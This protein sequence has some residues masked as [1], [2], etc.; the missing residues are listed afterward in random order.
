MRTFTTTCPRCG[1]VSLAPEQIELWVFPD[2]F[3]EDGYAFTCPSCHERIRKPA[4]ADIIR[5]LHTGGVEPI[6]RAGHPEAPPAGLPP[7][8]H[9]DLLE[10]QQLLQRDDWLAA[11]LA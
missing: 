5:L 1:K 9:D 4:S 8:S 10:F 2:G 3:G 11:H 6:E 7:I